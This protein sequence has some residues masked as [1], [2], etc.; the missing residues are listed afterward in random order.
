MIEE[1]PVV[2]VDEIDKKLGEEIEGVFGYEVIEKGDGDVVL[3]ID[4][5][6]FKQSKR[7]L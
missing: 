3:K 2:E 5:M 7:I 6:T 1:K 4:T